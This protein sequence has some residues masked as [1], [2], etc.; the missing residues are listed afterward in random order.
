[1][2]IVIDIGRLI[3]V[4]RFLGIA[5]TWIIVDPK[6]TSGIPLLQ[7]WRQVPEETVVAVGGDFVVLLRLVVSTCFS[8]LLYLTRTKYTLRK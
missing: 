4:D 7:G 8:H 2:D 5:R 3:V 6:V 1:M